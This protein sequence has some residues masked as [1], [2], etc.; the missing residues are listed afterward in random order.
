MAPGCTLVTSPPNMRFMLALKDLV[1]KGEWR[2]VE[3]GVRDRTHLRFFTLDLVSNSG[4]HD[5][6]EGVMIS[7][8]H[9]IFH[10][11]VRKRPS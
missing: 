6:N 10:G 11:L 7:S 3:Q 2:Y 1:L 5:R 8:P 9:R 4:G